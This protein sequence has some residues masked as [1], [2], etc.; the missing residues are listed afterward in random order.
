MKRPRI[1]LDVDGVLTSG[2]VDGVCRALGGWGINVGP[3]DVDQWDFWKSLSV[4]PD[5]RY[6]IKERMQGLGVA[7]SF[8]TLP[9]SYEF[10]AAC[11]EWADVYYVTSPMPGPYWA[12]E[13]EEWL[14]S[15]YGANRHQIISCHDKFVVAGDAFIDDKL[16]NLQ[17]WSREWPT[18]G[19]PILWR[20]PSNRHD[21]WIFEASTYEELL[22]L[23]D[24]LKQRR[25]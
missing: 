2:F 16:E 13:R 18:S 6:A 14:V 8:K 10:V 11:Q 23:L 25:A 22:I 12:Y 17:R 7:L 3:G 9:G 20:L 15:N 4:P 1:L 5:I 21:K 19:V 24:P